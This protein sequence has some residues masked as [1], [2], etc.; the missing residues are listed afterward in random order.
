MKN[1]SC[2]P[3][4][5]C[6]VCNPSKMTTNPVIISHPEVSLLQEQKC[7]LMNH[8]EDSKCNSTITSSPSVALNKSRNDMPSEVIGI[9]RE[10]SLYPYCSNSSSVAPLPNSFQPD[11]SYKNLSNVLTTT[12]LKEC[13]NSLESNS[14]GSGSIKLTGDE[15][16]DYGEMPTLEKNEIVG[17][18]YDFDQYSKSNSV[19]AKLNVDDKASLEDSQAKILEKDNVEEKSAKKTFKFDGLELEY[20]VDDISKTGERCITARCLRKRSKEEKEEPEKIEKPKRKRGASRSNAKKI[21]GFNIASVLETSLP[22]DEQLGHLSHISTHTSLMSP[23]THLSNMDNKPENTVFSKV[24]LS[25]S[26]DFSTPP[27]SD[28]SCPLGEFAFSSL[29]DVKSA[30]LGSS[31]VSSKLFCADQSICSGSVTHSSFSL[32]YSSALV[33]SSTST[34]SSSSAAFHCPTLPWSQSSIASPKSHA[35]SE[36][37]NSTFVSSVRQTR[38]LDLPVISSHPLSLSSIYMTPLSADIQLSCSNNDMARTICSP[39]HS[40][41][42]TPLS[43]SPPPPPPKF[44]RSFKEVDT[45]SVLV[46]SSPKHSVTSASTLP[47]T[48]QSSIDMPLNGSFS[49]SSCTPSQCDTSKFSGEC[50]IDRFTTQGFKTPLQES[51][52]IQL[53][54]SYPFV[55]PAIACY[56]SRDKLSLFEEKSMRL[57]RISQR[58]QAN[59]ANF[60]KNSNA[61]NEDKLQDVPEKLVIANQI[62]TE[63]KTY[64]EKK[65]EE[66]EESKRKLLDE[67]LKEY[68]L[69]NEEEIADYIG[70]QVQ[71]VKL[72]NKAYRLFCCLFPEVQMPLRL[73]PDSEAVDQL[74]KT[75]VNMLKEKERKDVKLDDTVTPLSEEKTLEDSLLCQ[76]SSRQQSKTE[77]QPQPRVILCCQPQ[78]CLLQLQGLVRQ[79]L[80]LVLPHLDA[81]LSSDASLSVMDKIVDRVVL[82]NCAFIGLSSTNGQSHSAAAEDHSTVGEARDLVNPEEPIR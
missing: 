76:S 50:Q 8:E 65:A 24:M 81:Y 80:C 17:Q 62:E 41:A 38:S 20:S 70:D 19:I 29:D 54:G 77:C 35:T 37:L 63:I 82:A 47:S 46:S 56:N 1:H 44:V 51:N 58:L 61:Q 22:Q 69:N 15:F 42:T 59:S 68:Y 45:S 57:H 60:I 74:L 16:E 21:K 78:K 33:V 52:S 30:S 34:I 26:F 48:A 23:M 25:Q 4:N 55:P 18:T 27:P 72:R 31:T 5:A 28:A 32:A 40:S 13:C 39:D 71:L 73:S 67:K 6:L 7:S 36:N 2:E 3:L 9:P 49:L 79:F 66:E 12:Q 53:S 43:P 14:K 64:P 75:A 10:G 11:G